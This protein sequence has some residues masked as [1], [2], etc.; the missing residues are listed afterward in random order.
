MDDL[1]NINDL[2]DLDGILNYKDG[3]EKELDAA[4]K[5]RE[6]VEVELYT[7]NLRILELQ[8]EIKDLQIKKNAIDQSMNKAKAVCMRLNLQIRRAND[9]Y[10]NLKHF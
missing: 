1:D 6:V 10:W 7:L 4:R 8:R 3:K 2:D 5:D 9:K